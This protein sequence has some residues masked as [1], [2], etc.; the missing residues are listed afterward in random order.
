MK[1]ALGR[2]NLC[3]FPPY[4]FQSLA[5]SPTKTS[6][7]ENDRVN[8]EKESEHSCT[9]I[10]ADTHYDAGT[11]NDSNLDEETIF[12]RFREAT[13]TIINLGKTDSG[14]ISGIDKFVSNCQRIK[15]NA[16]L[17]SAL[18]TFTKYG[19]PKKESS[20]LIPVQ[21]TS[22]VKRKALHKGRQLLPSGRPPK[23]S[24]VEHIY[25]EQSQPTPFYRTTGRKPNTVHN[26]AEAVTRNCRLSIT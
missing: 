16:A 22:I 13:E 4:W 25:S 23:K 24:Y 19:V 15:T 26:L 1:V 8:E 10:I 9:R 5:I 21:S 7:S 14:V 20:R 2:E 3:S 18:S 6:E 11:T 12:K 17:V